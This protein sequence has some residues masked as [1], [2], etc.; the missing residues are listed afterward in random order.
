MYTLCSYLVIQE[1]FVAY[2]KTKETFHLTQ[3]PQGALKC[4]SRDGIEK[5]RECCKVVRI[6]VLDIN[7]HKHNPVQ[8][9]VEK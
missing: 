4:K 9:F 5:A 3:P 7:P 8:H 2:F 1:V 6:V